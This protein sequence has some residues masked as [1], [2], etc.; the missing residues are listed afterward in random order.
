MF[1]S[2]SFT[3]A[4]IFVLDIN[5]DKTTPQDSIFCIVACTIDCLSLLTKDFHENFGILAGHKVSV[6]RTTQKIVGVTGSKLAR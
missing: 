4:S 5:H 2:S 6:I 1:L 3:E